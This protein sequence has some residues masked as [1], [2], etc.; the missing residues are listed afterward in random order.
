[1]RDEIRMWGGGVVKPPRIGLFVMIA[2]IISLCKV[3]LDSVLA[4]QICI[5]HG[6]E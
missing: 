1:M 6:L 3:S 5:P 2:I 4:E